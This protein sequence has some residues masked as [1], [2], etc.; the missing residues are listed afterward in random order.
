MTPF[1]DSLW[2]IA[3]LQLMHAFTF[4]AAHLGAVYFIADRMPEDI[5]ATAQTLYALI[6]SGFGI[7]LLSVLSGHLY[8]DYAGDAF[9]A[10]AIIGGIG[11]VLAWSIRRR[12]PTY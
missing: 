2:T 6:V 7:G 3:A 11:M 10:M 9:F 4:G 12:H 8:E 1:A 5:S